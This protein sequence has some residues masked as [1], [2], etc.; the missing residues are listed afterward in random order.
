MKNLRFLL[1]GA[2]AGGAFG[3]KIGGYLSAL[4]EVPAS[5]FW[6]ESGFIYGMLTGIFTVAAYLVG[7]A[8]AAYQ[9][10]PE[11]YVPK[12]MARA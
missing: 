5:S 4:L 12:T 3:A 1:I 8:V 9:R 10:A 6:I 7:F 11:A 2:V